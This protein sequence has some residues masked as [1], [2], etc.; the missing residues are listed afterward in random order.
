MSLVEQ[1]SIWT[2]AEDQ[3][4]GKWVRDEKRL[5]HDQW[6][7][8]RIK[9]RLKRFRTCLDIGAYIG[10]HTIAYAK[11]FEL[12]IAFEPNP[13]AFEC[14]QRNVPNGNVIN[15]PLAV[16]QRTS[17]KMDIISD[18]PGASSIAEGE[19]IRFIEPFGI[20]EVDYIKI[21][22]EGMEPEVLRACEHIIKECRPQM[23]IEQRRCD[24]NE[25]IIKQML[26]EFGY[27]Y[28]SIQGEEGEQYDLWCEKR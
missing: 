5:D 25:A 9:E 11:W 10:D 3:F 19:G 16:G 26:D 1:D 20:D 17:G 12:V 21:D 23:L 28:E 24:G 15:A 18:N 27:K 4:I 22:V 6:V 8:T 13:E 2:I 7:L 14:L